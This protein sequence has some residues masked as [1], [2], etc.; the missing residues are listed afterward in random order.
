MRSR[1]TL[2]TKRF[3]SKTV[4]KSEFNRLQPFTG[5]LI[6]LMRWMM[7]TLARACDALLL[8][9]LSSCSRLPIRM[10]LGITYITCMRAREAHEC[11]WMYGAFNWNKALG[12]HNGLTCRSLGVTCHSYQTTNYKNTSRRAERTAREPEKKP[13]TSIKPNCFIRLLNLLI[14]FYSISR[15]RTIAGK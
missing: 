13:T 7:M 12:K 1:F 14:R 3:I 6:Q 4:Y 11:R 2:G 8:G 15:A 5:N 10:A 9:Y